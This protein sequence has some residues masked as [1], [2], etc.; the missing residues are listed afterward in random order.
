MRV[1]RCSEALSRLMWLYGRPGFG[2][3]YNL[4]IINSRDHRFF[5]RDY[6]AG[7]EKRSIT[8]VFW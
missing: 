4:P 3:A 2:C 6:F 8:R 1:D 5:D 7:R